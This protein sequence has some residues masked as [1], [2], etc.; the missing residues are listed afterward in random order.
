MTFFVD[1]P[2]AG[3][4]KQTNIIALTGTGVPGNLTLVMAGSSFDVGHTFVAFEK[5]NT[6]G[7]TVRQVLGFYPDSFGPYSDGVVKDNSGHAY[8]VSL[9]RSV[10]SVEFISALAQ[11]KNDFNNKNYNVL[12]YNCTDAALYWMN[13]AGAN[14]ADKSR[15]VFKNTPGDYG[16]ELRNISTANKNGGIAPQSKGPCN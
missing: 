8:D 10:T 5:I 3:T 14:L 7:S 15:G 4:N 12:N 2:I 11:V 9:S 6:D 16:Q 1:Q 13:A